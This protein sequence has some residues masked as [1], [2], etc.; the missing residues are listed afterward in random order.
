LRP[1]LICGRLLRAGGAPFLKKAAVFADDEFHVDRITG[2]KTFEF[3]AGE[4]YSSENVLIAQCNQA[5]QR[6]LQASI[7]SMPVTLSTE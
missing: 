3:S 2:E 6:P 1:F 7:E 4:H 5:V